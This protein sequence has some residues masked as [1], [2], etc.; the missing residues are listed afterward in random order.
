MVGKSRKESSK[1][2]ALEK[3]PALRPVSIMG[4]PFAASRVEMNAPTK[5]VGAPLT[6]RPAR[7]GRS[8]FRKPRKTA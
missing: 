4:A 3:A 5:N 2:E 8:V 7:R 6:P 1:D